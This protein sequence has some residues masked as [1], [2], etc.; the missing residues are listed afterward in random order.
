VGQL[1]SY[2][3]LL[4]GALDVVPKDMTKGLTAPAAKTA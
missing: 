1:E 2:G 4:E 3:F